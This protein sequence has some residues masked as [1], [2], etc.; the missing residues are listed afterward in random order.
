MHLDVDDSCVFIDVMNLLPIL[1]AVG[2]LEQTALFVWTPKPTER[3]DI[4]NV[5][6][7]RVNSDPTDLKGLFQP[8][9]LPGF[10]TI[11]RFVNTISPGNT[12]TWICLTGSNPNDIRIGLT[13][14][15][16][17]DGNR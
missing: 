14:F 17:P 1:A 5:G 15:H 16:V 12:V 10:A 4:N 9:V 6:I 8:H 2:C 3:T 11:S 13:D 7:F